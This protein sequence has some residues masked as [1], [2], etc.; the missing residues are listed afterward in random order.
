M[1]RIP[2]CLDTWLID[3]RKVVRFTIHSPCTP[4]NIFWHSFLLE[5]KKPQ[6]LVRL[7]GLSKLI[8]LIDLI[9]IRTRDLPSCSIYIYIYI[10]MCV[11]VCV[12]VRARVCVCVCVSGEA[13]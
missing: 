2:H 4:R 6:G 7:E 12:C 9:G 11:C 5:A 13:Q 10:Y 8:H 3:G 1:L